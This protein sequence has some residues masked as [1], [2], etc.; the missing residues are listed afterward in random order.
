MSYKNKNNK[1]QI[2]KINLQ[3][4]DKIYNRCNRNFKMCKPSW[5]VQIKQLTNDQNKF[6][7][8]NSWL[9]RWKGKSHKPI[10]MQFWH[11]Y[12]KIIIHWGLLHHLFQMV[13]LD[14]TV[15]LLIYSS[16]CSDSNYRVKYRCNSKV[17]YHIHLISILIFNKLL[18]KMYKICLSQLN[19]Q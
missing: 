13:W 15:T 8:I 14:Y 7:F 19:N 2:Y 17:L 18:Y 11:Q 16:T 4:S 9:N 1:F 5:K 12:N 6:S 3:Y 10:R